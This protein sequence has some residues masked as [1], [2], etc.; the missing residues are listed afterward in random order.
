MPTMSAPTQFDAVLAKLQARMPTLW[1]NDRL[2]Q[3]LP[4]TAPSTASISG[5]EARMARCAPLLVELFPELSDTDGHIE[6]AL[7]PA[8]NLKAALSCDSTAGGGVWFIKRDDALPVAGSIKAR[9]GFHEVLA[10]AEE[11]ALTRGLILPDDDRR[12]LNTPE[13][14]AVFAQYTVAVGSTG[15]LGLSIGVMAAAL[16]FDAVVH[17][18]ADAKAWKKERLRKRGVRV[19]EHAGD[20][21]KAVAGGRAQALALPHS[22]FVDD[23]RSDLL[24][25][26]YAASARYLAAQLK[27]AG[28]QVDAQHPLFVYLPCGVGGAPGGITYGLKALFG[29]HVHC[30]FAEPVASPCMLVQLA[31]HSDTP[32]SVYDIGLDNKTDADGLAVGEA[33]HLVAPLMA[34]QLSGVF[35]VSDTELFLNLRALKASLGVWVEPSAAAGIPGPR[36]LSDSAQGRAYV[37]RHALDMRQATHVIWSTGGSLVPPEEHRAF[38]DHAD[39]LARRGEAALQIS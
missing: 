36:W 37:E 29:E 2:G 1:L 22:H 17:M 4:A 33:S 7:M 25:F 8:D 31:S 21:A 34:S 20:Y 38:H 14:R 6:S 11:I 12:R 9:G 32:I 16:G 35:T 27:D 19:V 28:R 3:P 23:E 18:S 24:F 10:V 5:A 13:V 15:N 39:E 26:G 30:F